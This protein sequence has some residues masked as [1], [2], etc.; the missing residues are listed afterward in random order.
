VI[1]ISLTV[2]GI[3]IA[4]IPQINL[5]IKGYGV[6]IIPN[7]DGQNV[8]IAKLKSKLIVPPETYILL[9]TAP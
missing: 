7:Q 4:T 9:S 3:S 2:L 5:M 6:I 1:K 8:K